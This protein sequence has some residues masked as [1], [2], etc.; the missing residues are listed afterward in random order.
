MY[1]IL[2]LTEDALTP[3]D[4]ERVAHLHDPEPVQAHVLVPVDTH[5]NRLVEALDDVAL[6]RLAEA[7][8]EPGPSSPDEA[9]RRAQQALDASVTALATAGVSATGA[10]TGDDPV[11]EAAVAANE[12]GVDEVIVVT[13][14]HFVE[15]TVRR[16]W[17]SRLREASGLPLLHVIAGTD[18]VVS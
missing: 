9:R 8:R 14:P 10:L 16:D 13:E 12:L 11:D 5:R 6:G 17:A 2:V 3:H 18:R 4:V 1:T 15:E 7:V